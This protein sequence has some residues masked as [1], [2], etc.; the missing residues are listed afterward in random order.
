MGL[1]CLTAMRLKALVF[2]SVLALASLGGLAFGAVRIYHNDFESRSDEKALNLSGKGCETKIRGNKGQL[3]VSTSEGGSRCRMRL[4]VIGDSAQPNHIVDVT[5][6]LLPKTP[7]QIR[8]KVY[9]AVTVREGGGGYYELRIYPE[10]RKYQLTRKP[11]DNAFPV[12]AK[13]KEI[14]KT[15]D[16]NKLTLRALG[17]VVGGKVNK[18]TI[19]D[20]VDPQPGALP[21]SRIS[22]V[23]GQEGRSSD[24]ASAWFSDLRVS[25]PNP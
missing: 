19:E 18:A 23:L 21:G 6:K 15:G 24:G 12:Q 13:D 5:A 9:V 7:D 3:G 16:K 8:R 2:A 10:K 14:G 20:V 4:P 22:I 17:D 1:R 25:V 11:G